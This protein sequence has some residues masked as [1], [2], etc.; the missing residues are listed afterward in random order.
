MNVSASNWPSSNGQRSR[1]AFLEA[2]LAR[3]AGERQPFCRPSASI[4]RALVDADDEAV[5]LAHELARDG[6]VPVATSSTVSVGPASI[7]ETRKRRQRGSWPNESTAPQ[8][9]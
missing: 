4:S 6:A 3:R 1:V 9:S 7:R 5:L 8:R 2:H